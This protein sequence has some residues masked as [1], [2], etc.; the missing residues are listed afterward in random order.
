M[1]ELLVHLKAKDPFGYPKT[2]IYMDN[3]AYHTSNNVSNF[4]K[5]MNLNYIYAPPYCSWL[6]LIELFFGTLKKRM[7]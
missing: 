2:L 6:N 1:R 7:N 3:A 5:M 4:M